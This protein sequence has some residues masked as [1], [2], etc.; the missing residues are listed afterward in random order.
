MRRFL[1]ALHDRCWLAGLG[2]IALSKVGSY[3]DMSIID[4]SV[5]APE[6]L[7]FEGAPIVEPPLE[8][9]RERRRPIATPGVTTDTLAACPPLTTSETAEV[10][11]LKNNAKQALATERAKLLG[12]RARALAHRA[13]DRRRRRAQDRRQPVRRA[14]ALQ[15]RAGVR[16][17]RADRQ[18]RGGRARRLRPR[19]RTRRWPTRSTAPRKGDARPR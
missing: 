12:D 9:D 1:E 5:G 15:S 19:S 16:R 13:G 17:R 11:R 10:S 6:R 8:Q 7:V 18:D 14:A 3:R 4:V 2:W